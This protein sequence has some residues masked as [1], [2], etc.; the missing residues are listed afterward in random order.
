MEVMTMGIIWD[1]VLLV[2]LAVCVFLAYRKGLIATL[3]SLLGAIIALVGAWVLSTPVGVLID[4]NFVHA[5]V[6]SMVLSTL[7][8]TPVLQYEEALADLDVAARIRAMPDA[9]KS[10]LESVGISSAD[11]IAG[12][13]S[14]TSASADAKNQLIDSIA[15]P[16]SATISTAIAFIVL[17]IVL[18]ILCMVVSKLL[19]ALCGLLPLGKKLNAVGGGVVGLV[20]GLVIVLVV[21]A[22]LWAVSAGAGEGLFSRETLNSTLITK[23]IVKINPICDIFR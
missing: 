8:D 13:E 21:T 6:R 12:A 4:Q 19:S 22:V 10:L 1:L 17:F 23:E 20:K 5:P 2:I 3:F 9:L 7:S 16:I 18:L 15:S 14:V 11:I